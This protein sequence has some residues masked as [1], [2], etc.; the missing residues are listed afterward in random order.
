MTPCRAPGSASFFWLLL[1]WGA[2]TSV[3]QEQVMESL[4]KKANVGDWV[5]FKAD[6]SGPEILG[7]RSSTT[8]TI[9]YTVK[10]KTES[11]AVLLVKSWSGALETGE[12]ELKI[13]LDKPVD[14]AM[15]VPTSDDADLKLVETFQD[16]KYKIKQ[17]EFAG[18]G[19]KYK[20]SIDLFGKLLPENSKD[21]GN[22]KPKEKGR[23]MEMTI[24]IFLSPEAPVLGIVAMGMNGIQAV[25]YELSDGT[26]VG[27]LLYPPVPEKPTR[28][29]IAN[30]G[31]WLE[32]KGTNQIDGREVVLRHT[33][34]AKEKQRI[35]DNKEGK[36]ADCIR[37]QAKLSVD[38]NE[39][40][41]W[42]IIEP[43]HSIL[44]ALPHW[45]E[46]GFTGKHE[47]LRRGMQN[48]HAPVRVLGDKWIDGWFTNAL[49]LTVKIDG[50]NQTIYVDEG[51]NEEVPLTGI[52][53]FQL[54]RSSVVDVQLDLAD[55]S[56]C[57]T[58]TK[59]VPAPKSKEEK[60]AAR[61]AKADAKKK[62]KEDADEMEPK[63]KPKAKV[64]TKE[65]PTKSK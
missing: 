47:S 63:T 7:K 33:V 16:K 62:R 46:W 61:K 24:A 2:A 3:A 36:E 54:R 42:E 25:K 57:V 28:A 20:M 32:Y 8:A 59:T 41:A 6:V 18:T 10:D 5:E 45:S 14:V 43:G 4:L 15:F 19:Y 44:S 35:P 51:S 17:K 38:G 37:I 48:K 50:K 65:K 29:A 31:D 39:V 27:P 64:K 58:I 52:A 53:S 49:Q 12:Y 13:P 21:D 1:I 9:R 11:K 22:G 30:V 56:G 26:G 34:I 55:H 23:G 60:E 40:D